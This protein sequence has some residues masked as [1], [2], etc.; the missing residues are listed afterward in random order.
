MRSS[1]IPAVQSNTVI[2]TLRFTAP[3]GPTVVE[4]LLRDPSFVAVSINIGRCRLLF[5]YFGHSSPPVGKLRPN[6]ADFGRGLADVGQC[7]TTVDSVRPHLSDLGPVLAT[8]WSKLTNDLQ[9][10]TNLGRT[11][12]NARQIW[13]TSTNMLATF[14]EYR[15]ISA[16]SLPTSDHTGQSP[17]HV[18]D[19]CWPRHSSNGTI[20]R[21]R[22]LSE[23]PECRSC[24]WGATTWVY[25]YW[26]CN[27]VPTR[28]VGGLAGRVR[29]LASYSPQPL[30][31][32]LREG[33][34]PGPRS[35]W[36]PRR[37]QGIISPLS[38][39]RIAWEILW[40]I[41]ISFD[42]WLVP[43]RLLFF[44]GPLGARTPLTS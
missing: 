22:H 20:L 29:V 30:S 28:R 18:F 35:R 31:R 19:R 3:A 15:S 4:Q 9:N 32:N 38:Q 43:F 37:T 5:V 17:D 14:S 23:P 21:A 12:S 39:R 13:P 1:G 33:S 27:I 26:L 7:V 25:T 8:H 24:A 36:P 34:G 42:V 40:C 6:S 2:A 41:A 10:S 11:W 44:S 16:I